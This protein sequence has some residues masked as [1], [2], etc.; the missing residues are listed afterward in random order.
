MALSLKI[1][2]RIYDVLFYLLLVLS[3]YFTRNALCRIMMVVFFGYTLFQQYIHK[4]KTPVLFFT[5]G[6]LVF[7]LYGGLNV[8]IG[9]VV[10]TQVARTMVVSLFLNFLMLYAIVQYI[11]MKRDV[12]YV[13]KITELAIFSTAFVVLLLSWN[14]IT[15]GRL[16]GATEM[17]SNMLAMLCVYGLSLAMYLRKIRKHTRLT[18]WF[19]MVFYILVVLLTGSRKGVIMIALAIVVVQ[20]FLERRK[21]FKNILIAMAVVF[22]LY[23]LIM[24]VEV[25]YNIIGTRIQSIIQFL[26]EGTTEDGS[27]KSRQLL[28]KIGW[29]YIK[30][31]PWTGYGYDCFKLLSGVNAEGTVNIGNVGYYSHNNYIELLTGGGIIGLVLYYIP[32]FYLLVMLFKRVQSNIC[33]PYLLAILI[34]KLAIEFA[35]V[36]YYSRMDIYIVAIVLGC[37]IASDKAQKNKSV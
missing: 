25:L 22:T 29:S 32:V 37:I 9:N 21:I 13:L 30:E 7:I 23:I 8:L 31:K 15:Q 26:E 16:G 34:S 35:F 10:N 24:N 3:F 19:R 12:P 4:S 36:S 33:M 27:L 20:T 28:V 1:R 14:T 18:Y 2:F 6:F 11:Y 5:V 17:N